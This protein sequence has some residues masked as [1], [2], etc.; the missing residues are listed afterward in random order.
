MAEIVW[1]F[2][3]GVTQSTITRATARNI[4]PAKRRMVLD[5]DVP[6]MRASWTPRPA[7]TSTK[8]A[9]I[10]INSMAKNLSDGPRNQEE[11]SRGRIRRGHRPASRLRY[12]IARQLRREAVVEL[13]QALDDDL[14]P[15]Q[16]G[17]EIGV[18]VP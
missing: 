12:R 10:M 9:R 3:R 7:T 4:T 16:H 13:E 8:R 1:I 11:R 6:P 15:P 5:C 17:H 14:G 18:A 2:L